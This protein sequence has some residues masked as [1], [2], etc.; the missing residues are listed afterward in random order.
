MESGIFL[1][2]RLKTNDAFKTFGLAV[3]AYLIASIIGTF[4]VAG[5][6]GINGEEEMSLLR[7]L[8]LIGFYQIVLFLLALI[9]CRTKSVPLKEQIKAKKGLNL[10]QLILIPVICMT[11][12]MFMLPVQT[13]FA[14]GLEKLG[15]AAL[16]DGFTISS[17]ADIFAAFLVVC[18][19][20][21][22][23][24]ET[25][26]RGIIG[27]A[28]ANSTGKVFKAALVSGALFSLMHMNPYQTLHTFMLG[29]IA[30]LL[31]QKSGSFWACF[32]MHFCNNFIA[33][34]LLGDWAESLVL[35][36]S[37]LLIS[38]GIL[39]T[40][41][42]M[43]LFWRVSGRLNRKAA[44]ASM[45]SKSDGLPGEMV[46]ESAGFKTNFST[47]EAASQN[48]QGNGNLEDES[49]FSNRTALPGEDKITGPGVCL[50]AIGVL[51]CS[52]MWVFTLLNGTAG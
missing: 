9:Y 14:Y 39:L 50:L 47:A 6:A 30:C 27:N 19:L 26:F 24:E 34:F 46:K 8:A 52:F 4:I 20:P 2:S 51:I 35:N 12:M 7:Q 18:I 29:V 25:I 3:L 5:A 45:E 41:F 22:F 48:L 43:L 13:W 11:L 44:A 37:P 21:S 17:T 28:V 31:L 49:K 1:H 40:A 32:L 42:F 23:C 33:T 15:F 16:E 38:S 36:Y 10:P